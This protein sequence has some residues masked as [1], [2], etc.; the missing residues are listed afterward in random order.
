M[1]PQKFVEQR[2]PVGGSCD[3]TAFGSHAQRV[4]FSQQPWNSLEA[5]AEEKVVAKEERD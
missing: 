2:P 3:S 4:Q 5:T 1:C